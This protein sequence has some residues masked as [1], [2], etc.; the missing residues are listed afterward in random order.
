MTVIA[1]VVEGDRAYMAADRLVAWGMVCANGKA[2]I[3]RMG[4]ALVGL[5]GGTLYWA[6]LRHAAVLFEPRDGLTEALVEDWLQGLVDGLRAWA[7]A[8]GHGATE[9]R[10]KVHDTYGLVAT[11]VGLWEFSCDGS[12]TRVPASGWA[13]G[14]GAELALGALYAT[15]GRPPAERVRI[16]CEAAV[17]HSTGCG[18]PLDLLQLLPDE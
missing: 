15:R 16:A 2:K 11:P 13:Q 7:E 18:G 6:H 5:S 10:A 4:S 12:Y 14:C 1:A 17:A 8:R 3:C 9:G